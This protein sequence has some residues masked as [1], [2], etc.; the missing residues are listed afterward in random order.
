[1]T[2]SLVRRHAA[3]VTTAAYLAAVGYAG[4]TFG[5][6]DA[7]APNFSSVVAQLLTCYLAGMVLYLWSDR[8]RVDGRIAAAAAVLVVGC[9]Y[10]GVMHVFGGLPLAYLLLWAGVAIPARWVQRDDI[11]YGVY[12]Y[13]FPVQVSLGWF[14]LGLPVPAHVAVA[15]LIT[16][17]LA[18]LSWRLVERPALRLRHLDVRKRP[19]RP[20]SSGARE[21]SS[22]GQV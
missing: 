16:C 17:L 20:K 1:M 18:F 19:T 22:A 11:S 14:V 2:T 6:I 15:L 12:V 4:W 3:L 13:A 10:A 9:W 7:A 5:R 8:I 21:V